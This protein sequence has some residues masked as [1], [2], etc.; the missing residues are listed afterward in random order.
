MIND[1]LQ[2]CLL[3]F[4]VFLD[5]TFICSNHMSILCR[6]NF[7]NVRTLCKIRHYCT[8][9]VNSLVSISDLYPYNCKF[10]LA[11]CTSCHT[12]CFRVLHVHKHKICRLIMF[13]TCTSIMQNI[14]RTQADSSSS[15][16]Y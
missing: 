14:L 13:N 6:T 2:C 9:F 4:G 8:K 15:Y 16:Y 3:S 5:I 12:R 1:G 11:T 10:L 7:V